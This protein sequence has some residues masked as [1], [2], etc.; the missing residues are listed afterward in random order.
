[1]KNEK[2]LIICYFGEGK[3]KTTAALGLALRASGADKKVKIIQ[4]IKGPWKSSE[5]KSIEKN[6]NIELEKIG[7]GFVGILTDKKHIKEHHGAARKGLKIARDS[8]KQ[9]DLFILILDEILGAIRGGL[10]KVDDVIELIKLKPRRLNLVLTGRSKIKEIIDL[11]DLVSEMKEI[12][13]P[14]RKGDIARRGIDY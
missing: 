14:Y 8:Y 3:G 5:E 13:H 4:F 7:L 1:M 10:L 12:K 9:K 11:C 6:A 2:G